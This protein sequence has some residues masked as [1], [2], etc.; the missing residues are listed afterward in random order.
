MLDSCF[1]FQSEIQFLQVLILLCPIIEKSAFNLLI[2]V[3][4]LVL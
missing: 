4:L 2:L 1:I 3:N